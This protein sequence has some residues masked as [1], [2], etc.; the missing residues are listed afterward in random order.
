M[1]LWQN[2]GILVFKYSIN[3]FLIVVCTS[4]SVKWVK[5]HRKCPICNVSVKPSSISLISFDESE[6]NAVQARMFQG[7]KLMKSY[8]TKIDSIVKNII[9]ILQN[10]SSSK[11]LIFSQWEDVL[12]IIGQALKIQKVGYIFLDGRGYRNTE[13]DFRRSKNECLALFKD[14][15][16]EINCLLL[17]AKSQSSGLNLTEARHV[18][19]VEPLLHK[20]LEQQAIGRIHRI[21]QEKE[22]AIYRYLIEGSVEMFLQT[23]QAEDQDSE[24]IGVSKKGKG[25]VI[26]S[27]LLVSFFEPFFPCNEET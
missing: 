16:S 6:K 19:L 7:I 15:F 24:A 12:T 4:C 23:C 1:E 11:I 5:L 9:F 8:G 25:E 27:D 3:S 2:A 26:S 18:F 10:D 20:G 22:T 14:D 13:G 21:G 17:H